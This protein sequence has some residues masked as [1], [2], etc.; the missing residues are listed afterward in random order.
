MANEQM[1][2]FEAIALMNKSIMRTTPKSWVLV[3]DG[4]IVGNIDKTDSGYV[5]TSEGVTTEPF[6]HFA[7]AI[8]SMIDNFIR[9]AFYLKNRKAFQDAIN[10][11]QPRVKYFAANPNNDPFVITLRADETTA[12]SVLTS[13]GVSDFH[14]CDI[15]HE[16]IPKSIV[17]IPDFISAKARAEE[18]VKSINAGL[19][20][21]NA[22]NPF[23]KREIRAMRFSEAHAENIKYYMRQIDD[24]TLNAHAMGLRNA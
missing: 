12:V 21:E 1:K 17:L 14:W 8:S 5:V 23:F 16:K 6:G 11:M 9:C 10:H 20:N 3:F 15:H 22:E 2:R 19:G 24:L 13:D 4:V 18:V 7:K